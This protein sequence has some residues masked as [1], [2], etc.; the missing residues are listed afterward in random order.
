M[1]EHSDPKYWHTPFEK[2]DVLYGL[3][4]NAER[5][6]TQRFAILAEGPMDII[7]SYDAGYGAVAGLGTTFHIEQALLLRRYTDTVMV[8]YDNDAAGARASKHAIPV[9]KEVGMKV[10]VPI[11]RMGHDPS[12][13]WEKHG[14][15]GILRILDGTKEY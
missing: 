2:S 1:S 4:E 14:R 7:A 3:Y 10:V 15:R 9:L 5:I 11:L 8:W 6:S 13:T 12:D